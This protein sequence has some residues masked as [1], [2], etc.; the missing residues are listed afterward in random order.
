M[1]NG[2]LLWLIAFLLFLIFIVLL[3]RKK[4]EFEPVSDIREIVF[5]FFDQVINHLTDIQSEIRKETGAI[6]SEIQKVAMS[7]LQ[8]NSKISEE[9]NRIEVLLAKNLRALDGRHFEEKKEKRK[10]AQITHP[11]K[12]EKR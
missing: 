4:V 12:V 9:L 7:N 11:W 5:A 8:V 3:A 1:M 2:I 6:G 10:V